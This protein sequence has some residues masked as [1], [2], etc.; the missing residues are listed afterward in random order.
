MAMRYHF[1]VVPPRRLIKLHI[2]ET[3]RG[4]SAVA[5]FNGRQRPLDNVGLLRALFASTQVDAE[6]RGRDPVAAQA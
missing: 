6:N 4:R 3:D 2:L 5:T 1:L